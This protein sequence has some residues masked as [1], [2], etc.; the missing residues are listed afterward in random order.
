MRNKIYQKEISIGSTHIMLKTDTQ[1]DIENIILQQR[2]IIQ[3]TINK[4]PKFKGYKPTEIIKKPR[5]LELMTC[6]G[7]IAETGPMAAVAGS[8]SQV[9]L[10]ELMKHDTKF[11]IIENGGDIALKT[12]KKITLGVYAGES[13]FT[14]NIGLKLGKYKQGYGICTSSGTVG[15]SESFGKTDAT[16]VFSKNASISDS[17][18]TQIAN[19]GRG[20]TDEEIVENSLEKA[21]QYEEYYDGVIVIKGEYLAKIGKIPQIVNIE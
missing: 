6:A 15:P 10:E 11:T 9:C 18:A 19:Y 1:H 20:E 13:I 2:Q 21:E 5:I 4:N 3:D 16:I 12:D 8:I 14:N 17:L 7:Q